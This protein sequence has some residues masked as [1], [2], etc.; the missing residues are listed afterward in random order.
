MCDERSIARK[1]C[2]ELIGLCCVKNCP[3][4]CITSPEHHSQRENLIATANNWISNVES[5]GDFD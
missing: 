4:F 3:L 2:D 5:G 1:Q